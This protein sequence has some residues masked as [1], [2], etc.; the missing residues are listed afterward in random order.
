[1]QNIAKV[2][3]SAPTWA[4]VDR[5]LRA[6]AG[7]RA[8]LDAEEARWLREA[9]ALQIWKPLGMVS[10]LDYM[11]RILGYA[12]RTAQERLRVARALGTLPA[13]TKAMERGEPSFSAARELTR[14]ATPATEREWLDA[15]RGM[16]LR[17]I[18][19]RVAGHRPGDRPDE[20]A[21]IEPRTHVLRLELWPETYAALRQA[22]RVLEEEHGRHLD[23]NELIAALA[24]GAL[25]GESNGQARHQVVVARCDM[26]RR[27]S[28]HGAGARIAIDHNAVERAECDAQHVVDGR[29]TN[30]IPP[31]TAR[32]VR[33]RDHGRCRV[34]GCRSARNLEIH[35]IIHREHGGTHDP[36]NLIL[37]CSSCHQAHH[38]RRITIR[39]TADELE[40][41][42]AHV[43]VSHDATAALVQLGWKPAIVRAA[44]ADLDVDAPLEQVLRAA[45]QRCAALTG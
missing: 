35:H 42:R 36:S 45:L 11:E 14:V 32:A 26:C 13:M 7:K 20:P 15:T 10:A 3:E 34:P 18:E 12:P 37:V 38:D 41:T 25:D 39:G 6:I 30:D 19:E 21:T 23:D 4:Q 29:A 24:H 33:L 2:E 16:N 44:L 9:E 28:Q 31:A 8:A 17:E 1:M 22:R 40:V 27:A 43:G 5:A